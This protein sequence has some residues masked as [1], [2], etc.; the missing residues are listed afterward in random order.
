MILPRRQNQSTNRGANRVASRD[1]RPGQSPPRESHSPLPWARASCQRLAPDSGRIVVQYLDGRPCSASDADHQS[2]HIDILKRRAY[3]PA[4]EYWL[5]GHP[6]VRILM[7]RPS[8]R[9]RRRPLVFMASCT[10]WVVVAANA[11]ENGENHRFRFAAD[12]LVSALLVAAAVST[13]RLVRGRQRS[14]SV[15]LSAVG[16]RLASQQGL[17]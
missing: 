15:S 9:A 6:G 8:Y 2:P 16:K 14:L 7:L 12:R 4:M 17:S 1:R 13:V 10:L 11:I 3:N 5:P